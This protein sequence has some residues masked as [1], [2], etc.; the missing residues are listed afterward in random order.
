MS[1]V[2]VPVKQIKSPVI[3]HPDADTLSLVQIEGY[4]CIHKKDAAGNHT[5]KEG[6]LVVYIPEGYTVPTWLLK[7]L[8]L[9]NDDENRGALSG[10]N[11][12]I[13]KARKLRGIFSQGILYPVNDKAI[14]LKN[15]FKIP[16]KPE[17]DV[18]GLLG[19]TKYEAPIP[20]TLSGD[21]LYLKDHTKKYDFENLQSRPNLFDDGEPVYANEKGHG[22]CFCIGY[23]KNLNHPE[24]IQGNIYSSSKGINAK[25][26]VFKNNKKIKPKWSKIIPFFGSYFSKKYTKYKLI[27]NP[28]LYQTILRS[29]VEKGF[30]NWLH[31]ISDMFNANTVHVYGE[32]YGKGI[33]DLTYGADNPETMFF[34][35]AVDGRFLNYTE[36]KQMM[37]LQSLVKMAPVLYEGPFNLE[38]LT[39]VRDGKTVIGGDNIREGIVVRSVDERTHPRY[40][41]KIAKMISPAYLL[42]KAK[43]GEELT[44]FN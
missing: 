19:I 1:D 22:T 8:N 6:D 42:R 5:L 2:I 25:G 43:K 3:D 44:E 30:D 21:V 38:E 9:W 39:K 40:G 17:M 14:V 41:R 23:V 15:S 31:T 7:K 16:V 20:K 11:R 26:N 35:I 37:A 18:A 24:L 34:D 12:D 28:C 13:V 29:L 32:I 36:L 33:Q 27:T 10:P 4:V